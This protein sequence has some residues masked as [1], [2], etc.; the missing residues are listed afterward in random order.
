MLQTSRQL[1]AAV[2]GRGGSLFPGHAACKGAIVK[3]SDVVKRYGCLSVSL[4]FNA[5]V[6][7]GVITEEIKVG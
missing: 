2:Q 3:T 1:P 4:F 7:H 6:I 5:L